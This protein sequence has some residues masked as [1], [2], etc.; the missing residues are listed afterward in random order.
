M[1]SESVVGAVFFIGIVIAIVTKSYLGIAFAAVAIPLV[2]AYMA[3]EQNILA[4]S[5]LYDRDLFVMMAITV[6]VILGFDKLW[7][8]RLGLIT[9]AVLV[10][11]IA[12]L[13]EKRKS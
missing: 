2:L 8:P 11:L 13:S 10:P 1:K 6:I 3:R 4:K 9:L 7:D 12:K 5:R